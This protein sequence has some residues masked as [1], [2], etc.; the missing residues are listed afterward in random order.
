L[1]VTEAGQGPADE[2]HEPAEEYHL[3]SERGHLQEHDGRGPKTPG[4]TPGEAKTIRHQVGNLPAAEK[5][6]RDERR[7]E[8]SL[9]EIGHE[10]GAEL[11]AAVFHE[12]ADDLRFPLGKIEGYT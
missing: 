3:Q 12:V 6:S 11:H 2:E 10:E 1:V 8:D 4:R 7:Y 9:H 5:K